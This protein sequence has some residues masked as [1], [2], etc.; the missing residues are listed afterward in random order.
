MTKQLF[1]MRH[2]EAEE[3]E[4]GVKDIDRNLTGDGEIV[5]SKMG[6]L[7]SGVIDN[8]EH[9]LCSTAMR[10]RQT[11]GM[12]AEQLQ[13]NPVNIDFTQELYEASTRILLRLVNELDDEYSKVIIV[14][15]NPSITYLT[16]YVS[17]AAIDSVS[18]AGIVELKHEGRWAEISEKNMDLIQYYDPSVV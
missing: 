10:T 11:A 3:A 13:F 18:P 15:H 17:G 2:A 8:M 7:L 16:E 5:A 6:R 4:Y 12:L 1:L 14:G 9:V